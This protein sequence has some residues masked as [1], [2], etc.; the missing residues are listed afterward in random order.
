MEL[1]RIKEAAQALHDARQKRHQIARL[2][3][4]CTPETLAEGYAI[5]KELIR[6]IGDQVVGWK[7]GCIA[8]EAQRRART[9]EPFSGPILRRDLYQSGCTVPADAYFSCALQVEFAFR[10][11]RDLSPSAA[12]FEARPLRK[13]IGD[14]VLALEIADSRFTDPNVIPAPGL[15]A[16][17]GKAGIFIMGTTEV[18]PMG[19]DLI[20]H[21]VTLEAN[22]R[23]VA[24]GRGGNVMG[25]PLNS[26]CWLANDMARRGE[27]LLKDQLVSTGTCT[28]SYVAKPGDRIVAD[29]GSLGS[30]HVSLGQRPV[31]AGVA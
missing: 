2:P 28:G 21:A 23:V 24:R 15:I 11:C 31:P 14:I 26:L 19:I 9:M 4:A 3:A 29:Y 17:G 16:D 5:Q 30:I 10:L 27:G 12:P 20:D 1:V 13:S 25:D 8:P 7:V 18:N 6:L 22:G